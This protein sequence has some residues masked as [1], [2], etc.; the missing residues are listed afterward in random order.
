MENPIAIT[1]PVNEPIEE[2]IEAKCMY[3]DMKTKTWT[4]LEPPN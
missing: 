4:E 3:L 1:I 2:G